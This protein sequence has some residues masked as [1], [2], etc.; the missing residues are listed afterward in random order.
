MLLQVDGSRH[1]WMEGR[2]PF[3]TLLAAIDDAT[4][5]VVAALFRDEEDAHGYML[6][7]HSI[8]TRHGIPLAIYSDRHSAFIHTE[9]ATETIDE[10]LAGQRNRTQVGRLLED[11]GVELILALSPQ[12][13]GRI[14]R[15]WGTFQD[16]LVSEL[17]L[18]K[19]ATKDE[20][21]E[22]LQHILPQHND[23]FACAPKEV[24]SAYRPAP[25]A[26]D[27][28]TAFSLQ[29]DR[30]VAN[31][32]TVRLGADIIQI[33]ANRERS[34]YAKA[35]TRIC[36]GLDGSMTIYYQGRRIAYQPCSDPNIVLRAQKLHR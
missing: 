2:G 20:A 35:K 4:G 19:A 11:L 21:S 27:L 16:R 23:R 30:T 26:L 14:E 36:V 10:Q 6:L 5:E 25:K 28:A 17:R 13:K 9:S 32:N 33:P 15:L 12:A 3:L 1:D 31:D 22:V 34:S 18:A 8:V 29:Y 7:L 24:T